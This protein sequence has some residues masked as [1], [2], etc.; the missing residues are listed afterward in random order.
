MYDM[1]YVCIMYDC[2]ISY[3][4]E[5]GCIYNYMV[6][7]VHEVYVLYMCDM[8]WDCKC[9]YNGVMCYGYTGYACI[10]CVI[11]WS[12]IDIYMCDMIL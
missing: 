8:M 2:M 3:V 11:W 12:Q 5:Y 6:V 7:W 4:Y 9:G 10:V 1:L